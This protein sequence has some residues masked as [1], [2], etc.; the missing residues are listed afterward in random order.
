MIIVNLKIDLCQF[1]PNAN[2]IACYF[3]FN[4]YKLGIRNAFLSVSKQRYHIWF[5][6]KLENK[7][8]K[9]SLPLDRRS[10]NSNKLE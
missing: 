7:K 6:V 2:K 3:P 1:C 8:I 10:I 4:N 9:K 5:F